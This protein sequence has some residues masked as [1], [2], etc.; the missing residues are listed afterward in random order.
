MI[1]LARVNAQI[2]QLSHRSQYQQTTQLKKKWAEDLNR[3]FPKEYRQMVSRYMKRCSTSL[4]VR[5]IQLKIPRWYYLMLV[6]IAIIK[7]YQ[8]MLE[9]TC[10]KGNP[11]I[12]LVGMKIHA[13]TMK[14]G[15][16]FPLKKEKKPRNR[17]TTW[18][19]NSTLGDIS[20]NK[21]KH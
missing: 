20:R 10:R 1:W 5:E 19:S 3:H 4:T 8:Q 15:M 13:V 9:R 21:Q 17:T 12:L 14:N 7:K 11:H 6:R 2:M 16:E 18:F